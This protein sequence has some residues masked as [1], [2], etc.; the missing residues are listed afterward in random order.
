[1]RDYIK[2]E[3]DGT[4]KDI[5]IAAVSAAILVVLGIALREPV[6]KWHKEMST[7]PL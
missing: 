5:I 2:S 3:D 4:K 1:M 7:D 6:G